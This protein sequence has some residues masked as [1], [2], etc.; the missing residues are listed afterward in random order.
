MLKTAKL[1]TQ[2][3]YRL[4]DIHDKFLR[5]YCLPAADL[6]LEVELAADN[7]QILCTSDLLMRL[8]R[9]NQVEKPMVHYSF[10]NCSVQNSN[11][12]CIEDVRLWS[13]YMCDLIVLSRPFLFI[14]LP[15]NQ[16]LPVI[17]CFQDLFEIGQGCL[18]SFD[19]TRLDVS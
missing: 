9:G 5:L 1:S 3:F 10:L 13:T 19:L 18:Q 11:S 14:G 12:F 7:L 4:E 8:L 16:F 2:L 6:H 15:S 17:S